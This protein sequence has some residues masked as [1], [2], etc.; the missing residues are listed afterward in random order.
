MVKWLGCLVLA[1]C[2][3]SP[4]IACDDGRICPADTVCDD[5]HALCVAPEQVSACTGETDGAPC[6]AGPITG[7]C[8]GGVCLHAVCGDHIVEA[9]EA[10]DDGNTTD[11]DGCS[12]DCASNETCGNKVIDLVKGEQCDDGNFLDHDGCSS[13]C[14][15]ESPHWIAQSPPP[16]RENAMFA[17]DSRR[18]RL[19]MFGGVGQVGLFGDVW[20]WDGGQWTSV[21]VTSG[22]LARA[23][24]GMAFDAAHAQTV[25]FGG[26]SGTPHDDTWLWD[27]ASWTSADV[28][29]PS[30]RQMPLMVY[31][32]K[33]V[34]LFGGKPLSGP[35]LT[36]TW[37]WDGTQWTQLFPAH[38]PPGRESGVA[39]FDPVRGVIVLATGE[40]DP[41]TPPPDLFA[42]TWEFDGTDW[43]DVTPA[44]GAPQL[45]QAAMAYDP[46]SRH[47]LLFGG[48]SGGTI[49]AT[50]WAWDGSAWSQVTPPGTPIGRDGEGLVRAGGNLVMFG[51]VVSSSGNYVNETWT[52]SAGTWTKAQDPGPHTSFMMAG[53]PLHR[54]ALMFGGVVA[55]SGVADT[56]QLAGAGSTLLPAT[57][58]PSARTS[59]C[60]AYDPVH[61]NI[62]LF[63]GGTGSSGIPFLGETWILDS[64]GWSQR[65]PA[66]APTPRWRSTCAFDGTHVT[67]FG[68]ELPGG[69]YTNETWSWDGTTWTQMPTP[70]ALTARFVASA[71][72]DP[73]R[74]RLVMFGG[75]G[76]ANQPLRE[77]WIFDGASWTQAADGFAPPGTFQGAMA[78]NP[79]RQTLILAGGSG[80]S[81]DP[82]GA[83][84]WDGA[85]WHT[86][87]AANAP[88]N[89]FALG[90][91]SALD[92]GG[93][94]IY[95]GAE[96]GGPLGDRW[97]LRWD[98][99]QL[100]DLCTA[101]D[102]DGDG[103]TGC[104][105]PDC[106]PICRP[107]CPPGTSCPASAPSC[108]DGI[109]DPLRETCATCTVDCGAC[110]AICGDGI[111]EPGES[112]C[113]GDCP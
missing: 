33:R 97:E 63:G 82:L 2:V 68:G 47:T 108:G 58:A 76:A 31:D 10:C 24:G 42:D 74:S 5:A 105:D 51:G 87:A 96:S 40:D 72:F 50:S 94:F 101:I 46:I 78:W 93:I 25:L 15:A 100:S 11:G 13:A 73:V 112:T 85:H 103:L 55:T 70:D 12:A 83:Y 81:V 44:G 48:T 110:P 27:G 77:T 39:S 6:T 20:E 43:H 54:S 18:D 4:S 104:A 26:A 52:L 91:I 41:L 89:R 29:G 95:G 19:V 38:A 21:P 3:T 106:W 53:D 92:G 23:L 59:A 61:Q 99:A 16:A 8:T 67:M 36:D 107:A 84:E 30:A 109:C 113:P 60:M 37:V 56:W 22:P 9:G 71:A 90:A 111:C 79:A 17:Y 64:T 34:V 69:I 86:I 65:T 7:S 14:L 88:T 98:A 102:L 32:G 28:E 57:P 66:S 49:Q 75:E 45:T 80:S 35:L 62:V 1:S